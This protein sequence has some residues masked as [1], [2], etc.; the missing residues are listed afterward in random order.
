MTSARDEARAILAD[1]RAPEGER[2]DAQAEMEAQHRPT[3]ASDLI[4]AEAFEPILK[5]IRSGE[6]EESLMK[7]RGGADIGGFPP[8]AGGRRSKAPE[9][10]RSVQLDEMQVAVG[11]EYFEKPGSIDFNALRGM[12]EGTPILSAVVGTRIRQI[13]RFC[14]PSEDGG[15]GFSIRHVDKE[16]EPTADDKEQMKMLTRFF[17]HGGW[18]FKPRARK[19]L[20]RDTFA[21]FMA[22]L[23][24]DSLTMDACPFETEMKR[25]GKGIDGMYAVDGSTVRLCMEAGYSGDDEVFALQVING[26]ITT[27][28]TMDQLTYEVRNPRADVRLAGYGLGETELLVRTVTCL[29]NAQAYNAD[30]FDKNTIP[31]GL[32]QIFG[33]Y[34]AE[35][36]SGFRRNWRQML[37]GAENRWG[38]PVMVSKDKESGAVYTPFNQTADE[39]AFA[40][41]LTFLTSLVCAIYNI[42][43]AEIGFESFSAGRS[44]LSGKD[45]G[46]KLT[47]SRDKGFRPLASFFEGVFTDFVV[48]DFNPNLCFRFEG[49]EEEDKDR[50]W[51]AKKLCLSVD[52]L[53]AEEG[54]KPFPDAKIG[55]LPVNPALIAPAMAL[56]N[57]PTGTGDF[58]GEAPEPAGGGEDFGGEAPAPE[59]AGT[60]FGGD[61]PAPEPEGTDFGGEAPPPPDKLSKAMAAFRRWR[62]LGGLLR[63]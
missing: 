32:L 13:M 2:F 45:T 20:K 48:T 3:S 15:V 7:A 31:K 11:G 19:A 41:W 25:N 10:M 36:I 21:T 50:A 63:K 5:A 27:T 51:E 14:Q 33:D 60:D 58:G 54:Y 59:P 29:L 40:K 30:F 38:L 24:R 1:S 9:G 47:A 49:L 6:A 42:D 12:V 57:P 56:Q 61:A 39:M 16:H 44:S 52:E 34:D 4:P 35:D 62:H 8:K 22:K 55:A 37:S 26:R 28:Y 46:E 17:Q 53:R 43:P 18:E 23:T